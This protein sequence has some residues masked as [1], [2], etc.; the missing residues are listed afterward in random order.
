MG[1]FHPVE[2]WPYIPLPLYLGQSHKAVERCKHYYDKRW[3]DYASPQVPHIAPLRRTV[4][5]EHSAD[6]G[7]TCTY[8][9]YE[10]GDQHDICNT[11]QSECHF[12]G[13]L[14]EV[15]GGTIKIL[16]S[17]QQERPNQQRH[18]HPGTRRY[19]ANYRVL[20]WHLAGVPFPKS[21]EPSPQKGRLHLSPTI[22]LSGV[23]LVRPHWT[24]DA[25]PSPIQP[26][27]VPSLSTPL[28]SLP[29]EPVKSTAPL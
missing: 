3:Q 21:A 22:P 5:N 19:H 25:Y 9:N 2:R 18:E 17:Q 27:E 29:T 6:Q 12:P 24:C 26:V 8:Q 15:R 11:A 4:K 16:P 7:N 14:Q 1:I 23:L 10:Y 28:P 20:A 13:C